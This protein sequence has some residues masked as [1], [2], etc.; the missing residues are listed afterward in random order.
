MTEHFT[1]AGLE[2]GGCFLRYY[3]AEAYDREQQK[4]KCQNFISRVRDKQE[5]DWTDGGYYFL[6]TGS[7]PKFTKL[8]ITRFLPND[9]EFHNADT[10]VTYSFE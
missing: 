2:R 5:Q 7:D 9:C 1:N 10:D 4:Q 6:Y 3:N 8:G